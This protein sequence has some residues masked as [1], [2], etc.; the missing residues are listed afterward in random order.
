MWF[1]LPLPLYRNQTAYTMIL[2]RLHIH[3]LART[4]ASRAAGGAT[5][6]TRGSR[7]LRLKRFSTGPFQIV[8]RPHSITSSSRA[9]SEGG[10]QHGN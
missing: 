7:D 9:S 2:K 4:L 1:T 5:D 6:A 8:S 3:T 10:N